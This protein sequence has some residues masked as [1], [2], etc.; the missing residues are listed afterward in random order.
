MLLVGDIFERALG[1]TSLGLPWQE[2]RD[3]IIE[4]AQ[5]NDFPHVTD[6]SGDNWCEVDFD[7]GQ[8][9]AFDGTEWR[10]LK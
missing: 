1:M 2:I 3:Q 8:R 6:V 9:I 10:W 7:N 4:L 5:N